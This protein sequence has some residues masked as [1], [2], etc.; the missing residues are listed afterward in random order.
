M[1]VAYAASNLL[2]RR[3]LWCDVVF[4]IQGEKEAGSGFVRVMRDYKESTGKIDA[5]LV[6]NLD[7][8]GEDTPCIMY[9]L[10]SVVHGT[11]DVFNSQPDLHSGVEGG[12]VYE[13]MCDG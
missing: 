4:L 13:P 9:G 1:A 10:R 2:R 5:L 6:S 8:I 3:L 12:S 11:I 7:W